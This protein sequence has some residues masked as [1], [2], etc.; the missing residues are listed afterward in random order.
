[1]NKLDEWLNQA[2][3][4]TLTREE[5]ERAIEYKRKHWK[6]IDYFELTK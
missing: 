2:L 5:R 6:P 4:W 3:F 1:M